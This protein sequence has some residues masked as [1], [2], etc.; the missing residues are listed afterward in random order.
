MTTRERI[1][2]AA[3]KEFAEKGLEGARVDSI[4]RSA[5]ANKA[6]IYYHFQ[7][8]ERL[9]DAV[10]Q[11]FLDR[12]K[13]FLQGV[14]RTEPDPEKLLLAIA[15]FYVDVFESAP[16]TPPILLREMAAGGDRARKL[17]ARMIAEIEAPQKVRARFEEGARKG[18]FRRLDPPHTFVSF[19]GMNLFYLMF[20]S[21]INSI[22]EIDD[23]KAFR[24][25]RPEAVVDL[26]LHGARAR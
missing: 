20:S 24:R 18:I 21:L 2:A 14:L 8:K 12:I 11:E 3:R 25:A 5:G 6:M 15:R 4:A 22:W 19:V 7:S 17:F 9:Y 1:L 13:V 23:D 26:F 10:V 16:D